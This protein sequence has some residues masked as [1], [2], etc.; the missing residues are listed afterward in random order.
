MLAMSTTDT[1][2]TIGTKIKTKAVHVNS[3]AK[4]S[5][6]Y[7]ANKKTRIIVGTVREV[8]IGPKVTAFGRRRTFVVARFDLEGGATKVAKINIR[9]VKLHATESP[10]ISIGGDVGKRAA[11]STTTNTGD[12]KVTYTVSVQVLEAP[13]PDPLNA[14]AFR[15]VVE[16]PMDENSVRPL[17]PS[18][19]EKYGCHGRKWFEED[20]GVKKTSM[21]LIH[22]AN[23]S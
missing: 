5:R 15:V 16:N 14:E 10:R 19:G 1:H 23:G 17:S 12:T 13:A 9:S 4:C 22:S 6:C 3:L 20:Y 7:G 21:V 11:S 2:C 8:E 18:T